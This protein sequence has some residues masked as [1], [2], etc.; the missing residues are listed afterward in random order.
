MKKIKDNFLTL[1]VAI[2]IIS[3][4]SLQLFSYVFNA[5]DPLAITAEVSTSIEQIFATDLSNPMLTN[6]YFSF[7]IPKGM[8]VYA[9][10]KNNFKVRSPKGYYEVHIFV[11][12][13]DTESYSR[14]K[15]ETETAYQLPKLNGEPVFFYI[16]DLGSDY[17]QVGL[18]TNR[19]EVTTSGS[20]KDLEVILLEAAQILKNVTVSTTSDNKIY[21]GGNNDSSQEKPSGEGGYGS[22]DDENTDKSGSNDKIAIGG[23]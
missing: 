4:F 11:S 10:N 13:L 1:M 23:N 21:I 22:Q 9:T 19:V 3:L 6:D 18:Y 14:T 16:K 2:V 15:Y 8:Q 7:V 17:I 20:K 5:T 12:D